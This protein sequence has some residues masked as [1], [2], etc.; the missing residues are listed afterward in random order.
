MAGTFAN[1]ST[2]NLG[3]VTVSELT[4]ISGPNY[5]SDTLDDTTHNNSDKFRTFKKGLT[6][7]GEISVDGLVN[8]TD[9][10]TFENALTS[11]SAYTATITMPT[12]PSVTMFVSSVYVTALESSAA[13]DGLLEFSATMKVTGKPTLS[14]V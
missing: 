6:D 3:G 12:T 4:N 10:D 9:F 11:M 14:Q 1:G 8:Y 13:H 7:P 5:S 2:L